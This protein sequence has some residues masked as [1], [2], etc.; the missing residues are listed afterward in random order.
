MKKY[1][2]GWYFLVIPLVICAILYPFL[3]DQVPRQWHT[4]GSVSY[5]AKEF[6]FLVALLPY[7]V[8]ISNRI[9]NKEK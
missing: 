7:V 5:M 6:L 2:K 9:K 8:Y 3:P 4:D 1:L